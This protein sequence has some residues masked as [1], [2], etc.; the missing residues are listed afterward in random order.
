MRVRTQEGDEEAP[1]TPVNDVS[2]TP[3]WSLDEE[4]DKK[5]F[6]LLTRKYTTASAI[7]ALTTIALDK[8]GI[9][10]QS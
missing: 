1:G 4:K 10:I 2:R 3:V 8:A 6:H 7:V 5:R 9:H